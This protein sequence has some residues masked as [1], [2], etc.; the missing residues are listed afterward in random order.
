MLKSWQSVK[1]KEDKIG[2]W[3]KAGYHKNNF[4]VSTKFL[5]A[6]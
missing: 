4:D 1:K 5:K 2:V 3:I 6:M